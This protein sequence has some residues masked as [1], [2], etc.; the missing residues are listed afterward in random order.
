[1]FDEP[2]E[3]GSE[4][5]FGAFEEMLRQSVRFVIN[6]EPDAEKFINLFTKLATD[7]FFEFF[8]YL[9]T[10]SK[11][12]LRRLARLFAMQIWN[13]TPLPSNHYRPQPLPLPK[14]NDP[15][16]CGSGRKYKQCCARLDADGMPP[17]APEMVTGLLLELITQAEL[18]RAYLHFPHDLLAF[19][20]GEWAKQDEKMAERALMMLDPIFRQPDA[21]LTHRDEMAL[22]AMFEICT[23]LGKPRKK[24]A[25]IKR[26][27][28]HPVKVLQTAALH[29]QCTILG[30]QGRDDEAWACFQQ[31]QRIDPNDPALSHLEL[32]LLMQQGKFEQMQQRG[33]YWLKRLNSMNRGGELNELI[34]LIEQMLS[35]APTA[36][37]PL[38]EQLTPGA[39]RLIAWLQQAMKKPPKPMEKIRYFDDCCQIE[40]KDQA[41]AKLLQQWN[42]LMFRHE[43]M[44]DNPDEW[45]LLLQEH[46]ELAGSIAVIDDLIQSVCQLEAPNPAVTFQPLIMLALLQIKS[47]IPMQPEQPLIWNIMDNRPALRVIGFLADSM[48]EL[49]DHDTALEMREWLLRLNPNDNQGMRALVVNSYLRLGRNDDAAALCA[50]YP[51][52]FDVS[53]CFGHALAL[54]RLGREDAANK[55]LIEAIG[56]SPRIV[57]ALLSKNMKEPK[58]VYPGCITLGGEDEAWHYR[59]DARELWL[60]TPGALAW[61]KKVARVVK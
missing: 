19:I 5:V 42:D 25:L 33:K 17:V 31:A 37:T 51:E 43:E 57:A 50:H 47:L 34:G 16:F 15:C 2:L 14:R 12:E 1:M 10:D 23:A 36:F 55:R 32:L 11:D 9:D 60:E 39:G 40:P 44:W 30:D 7:D 20:A 8:R 29:R 26:M 27:M 59:E 3:P 52:D 18:K 41:S 22:D 6:L 46:P 56:Q 28:N 53:I 54:F 24:S 58:S 35:D 4:E 38:L 61:L 13:A 45:L 48:E 49:D 21:K